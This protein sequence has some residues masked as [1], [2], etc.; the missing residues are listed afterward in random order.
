[1]TAETAGGR[2]LPA[3]AYAFLFPV[4]RAVLSW[5]HHTGLHEEA[6]A[7]VALHVSPSGPLPRAASLALLYHVLELMPAYRC[8]ASP[9][10]LVSYFHAEYFRGRLL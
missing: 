8:A 2:P 1:M 7:V 9:A 10:V 4:L 3:P 6:L 5:K